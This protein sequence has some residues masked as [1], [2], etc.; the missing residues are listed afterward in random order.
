MYF[1]PFLLDPWAI[2]HSSWDLAVSVA[3]EG[4]IIE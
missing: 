2:S 4:D 1:L 3:W